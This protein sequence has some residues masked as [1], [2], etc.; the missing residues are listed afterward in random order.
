MKNLQ[1]KNLDDNICVCNYR[2]FINGSSIYDIA[3][4]PVVY[5]HNYNFKMNVDKKVAKFK[6]IIL[7]WCA[8]IWDSKQEP[9]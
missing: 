2:L 4:Q 1:F 5:Q 6:M 7:F 8:F 3:T 9:M